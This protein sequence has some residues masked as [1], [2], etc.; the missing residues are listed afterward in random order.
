[1][2]PKSLRLCVGLALL[3]GCGGGS[4][5]AHRL[6]R[7]VAAALQRQIARAQVQLAASR[8]ELAV[9]LRQRDASAPR[10][11]IVAR[12][13]ATPTDQPTRSVTGFVEGP[14]GGP[15]A[16]V[17]VVFTVN[18]ANAGATGT[19]VPVDCRSD[20]NGVVTF[21][22]VA[23]NPGED[24][25]TIVCEPDIPAAT[26]VN[27]PPTQPPTQ[28][29]NQ[30]P[31]TPPPDHPKIFQVELRNCRNLHVGYN[32]FPDGAVVNWTVTRKDRVVSTGQ[33]TA[34]GAGDTYHFLTQPLGVTIPPYPDGAA[35]FSWQIN[36]V[37]STYSAARSPGC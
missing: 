33:F 16:G 35:N 22:Y 9:V 10:A 3:A 20:S 2:V 1:M 6:E 14:S 32:G 26:V 11:V 8:R 29:P 19:C 15:L 21:T 24:T 34:I 25:V 12:P 31:T 23:P 7:P 27:Q 28:P 4:S 5:K 30:P 36:G 13:V 18:G 17:F 37:T